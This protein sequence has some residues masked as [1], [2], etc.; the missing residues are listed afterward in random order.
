MLLRQCGI[1]LVNSEQLR[2]LQESGLSQIIGR[3][4]QE[5][6]SEDLLDFVYKNY[7]KSHSQLQQDLV[8]LYFNQKSSENTT[9]FYVEF[10]ATDGVTL[11]NSYLLEKEGWDGLLAEPDRN[12]H[13]KLSQ[14]RS[15]PIDERC[16]YSI[17][18]KTVPFRESEIGELSGIV[19]FANNDGW[20]NT[21]SHGTIHE[22][23]TV[24]LQELLMQNQA[25]HRIDFLSIDTEGSEYPIIENFD[26]QK[27]DIRFV[28]IEHNFT[29]S[30][31][32]IIQK[33]IS[34]GYRHILPQISAWD[35]WFVKETEN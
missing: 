20:S 32:K 18:G 5:D 24:S 23:E 10:G 17:S 2:A 15:A 25:P 27:W 9:P 26:F 11:S 30:K 35:V 6:V 33:M 31:E 1:R 12:W 16:V 7:Q 34:A 21:R 8:A 28:V 19:E 29:L 22:V 14:N 4:T 13:K 3:W